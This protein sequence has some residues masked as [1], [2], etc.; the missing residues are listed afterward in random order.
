MA[1]SVI[2]YGGKKTVRSEERFTK[3]VK[4]CEDIPTFS[5]MLWCNTLLFVPNNAN[6]LIA[7][8]VS[9]SIANQP[10]LS[11]VR[12]IFAIH[13]CPAICN[14]MHLF[15]NTFFIFGSTIL[16]RLHIV[17]RSCEISSYFLIQLALN[18]YFPVNLSCEVNDKNIKKTKGILT[19]RRRKKRRSPHDT[20]IYMRTASGVK[21]QWQVTDYH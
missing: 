21:S 14:L 19:I 20:E 5:K 11:F 1:P 6:A 15:W 13:A 3:Y 12:Y 4:A 18:I 7:G 16:K 8:C 10:F 17:W 2:I 9:H